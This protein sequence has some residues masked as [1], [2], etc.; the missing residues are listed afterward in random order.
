MARTTAPRIEVHPKNPEP[1]KIQQAVAALREGKVIVYPTDTIYGLGADL[2]QKRAIDQI[3]SLRQL[4]P[5]KP[6][7]LICGSLSEASRFAVI[8]DEC[9][10]TMKRLLPGPYTFILPATRAAPKTGMQQRR[11]VGIRI[12]DHPV[13]LALSAAMGL[14]M[15]S[16][17][18][19]LETGE[20][21]TSDPTDLAEQYGHAV[22]LVLDAG[23]LFGT[24]SSVIDW[25]G[26]APVILRRGA[27]D[28]SAFES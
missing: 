22:G 21:A 16:A 6:L 12:P 4:D 9:F 14:P 25:T 23:I 19:M 15:I 20:E 2:E 26:S 27:G 18:A 28:L 13:A 11:T 24:P 1:R 3:Y 8:P 5:K 17:S 10:R 7:S